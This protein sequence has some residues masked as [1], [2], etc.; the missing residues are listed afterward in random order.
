MTSDTYSPSVQL[1]MNLPEWSLTINQQQNA[2]MRA[3]FFYEHVRIREEWGLLNVK[4]PISYSPEAII[5][6]CRVPIAIK[7]G[8]ITACV[9]LDVS[10]VN[11]WFTCSSEN[12]L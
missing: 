10:K 1:Y 6:L 4:L 7:F 3:E 9:L 12:K 2:E 5:A 8:I 11:P